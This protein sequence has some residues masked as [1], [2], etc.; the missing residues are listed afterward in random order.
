MLHAIASAFIGVAAFISSLF[1]V[2]PAPQPTLGAALPSG[3]AVFETSLQSRISSTDASMTLVSNSVRG[4]SSLS[5][6]NCFTIDEGR[7]DAEYVCGTVSGTGVTSLARGIDPANGTSSNSALKSAHRVGANVKITDFPLLQI[8]RNQASG[9]DTYEHALTYATGVTPANTGD[10]TDKEYVDGLAFSGAGIVDASSVSRGVVEL[11]TQAETAS[12]TTTGNSGVLAIPASAATSTYNSATAPLRVVVTQNSGKIDDNFIAT[13]TLFATSS[14][15][16][17]PIGSVAKN[18]QAFTSTGTTTFSVPA[19]VTKIWVEVQGAGG[20]TYNTT[21]GTIVGGG[22][23]GGYWSGPISVAGTTSIQVFVGT[24]GTNNTNATGNAGGW[25]TFGTNGFYAYANGGTGGGSASAGTG[26]TASGAGGL[27]V[28]GASGQP[29]SGATSNYIGGKGGDSLY[30]AGGTV[31]FNGNA[32]NSTGYGA[33]ASG[34]SI[35]S[36]GCTSGS[37]TNGLVIVR[38]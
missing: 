25:S 13:S 26:G 23:A 7:T 28:Q 38:W 16:G 36:G 18:V 34:C 32:S 6:Y 10:L 33:G 35:S 31:G 29:G 9:A 24:A 19:G 37:A 20:G 30:G 14:F 4:G 17:G 15:S 5:G 8:L 27:P 11:A 21:G 22:G 2:A 3:T 12:S 1:G